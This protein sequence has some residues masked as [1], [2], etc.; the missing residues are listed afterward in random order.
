MSNR[1]HKFGFTLIEL[2]VVVSIITL[3]LAMSVPVLLRMRQQAHALVCSNHLH[4]WNLIFQ[5]YCAENDGWF[6][7]G[8]KDKI[9]TGGWWLTQLAPEIRD[10]KK[11]PFWF[12]PNAKSPLFDKYGNR[13]GK[14]TTYH[15]WGIEQNESYG[16]EGAA[17]SYGVNGYFIPI[18]PQGTYR[19]GISAQDGWGRLDTVKQAAQ[20]P[21]YLDALRFDLWPRAIDPPAS[22][23]F[24]AWTTENHMARA[25]INRHSRSIRCTFADGSTRR[26]GL[27]ELWR[28]KWHRSF[29]TSGRWTSRGGVRP[30]DWPEWIR[31]YP[32]Y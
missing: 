20:V 26:V 28:L 15:A 31:S 32:D 1:T 6:Y 5:T 14:W 13:A 18:P 7:P 22:Y 11:N 24:A 9:N 3:L 12:C 10:W 23:E 8:E 4:Q 25:C 2:L 27:K 16:P 30:E 17:G 29:D 21:F 19:N